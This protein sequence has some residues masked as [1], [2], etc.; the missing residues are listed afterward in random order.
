MG[1]VQTITNQ[2]ARLLPRQNQATTSTEVKAPVKPT[3]F[4]SKLAAAKTRRERIEV[5]REMYDTD[6]RAKGAVKM[7]AS[8]ATQGGFTITV[9]G[10]PQAR[11]AQEAADDLIDRLDLFQRLDDWLRLSIRDGDSFLESSVNRDRLIVTVT[12]K[13]TL[14]M[15]RE[16]NRYDRFD[17]PAMA[18]W[19]GDTIFGDNPTAD[20][21]WFA[22]WQIIHAR[23]EH[24]EGNRYGT[25]QFAVA[26]GAHKR[27]K[28]G[29][30]DMAVRRKTRAGQKRIHVIEGDDADIEAY[31]RRNQDTLNNPFAAIADFFT[32]KPGSIQTVEGDARLGEI[33][34]VEHHIQTWS[35]ASPVPL[36]LIGYGA[37]LNRDVLGNKREQYEAGLPGVTQWVES[38]I[39]RPLIEL[40]WLLLGIWPGDLDYE[41]EWAYQEKS[42]SQVAQEAA[43]ATTRKA[44]TITKAAEAGLKLRALGWPDELIARIVG[45]MVQAVEPEIDVDEI[46]A[47]IEAQ[48]A[49]QPDEIDR[50]AGLTNLPVTAQNGTNGAGQPA[51]EVAR[52]VVRAIECRM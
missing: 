28:E 40:Q 32:N 13:P 11:Q 6:P 49:S 16:S 26:T 34:D 10:G 22:D 39:A 29:E 2:I 46:L 51:S 36:E 14:E 44:E 52:E 47:Q 41:I 24:D 5:C 17:D 20:A 37:N 43:D 50:M 15:H 33:G 21:V 48:K 42:D 45:T 4:A 19:Q 18:Y 1:L 27:V 31:K 7:L 25:P 8:D 23:W 12:R 9:N 38:R 35:T 3:D 30:V